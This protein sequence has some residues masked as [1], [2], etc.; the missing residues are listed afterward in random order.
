MWNIFFPFEDENCCVGVICV[1]EVGML[2]VFPSSS[3]SRKEGT[4]IH[5]WLGEY[6]LSTLV[7]SLSEIRN[8]Y[9]NKMFFCVSVTIITNFY[10]TLEYFVMC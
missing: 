2:G 8:W 6:V 5:M 10:S 3:P 4:C 9:G 7:M 1:V